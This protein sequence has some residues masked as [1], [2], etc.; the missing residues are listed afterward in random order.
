M[1]MPVNKVDFFDSKKSLVILES[2]FCPVFVVS[3]FW[4]KVFGVSV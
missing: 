3:L 1:Q 2:Q 4:G